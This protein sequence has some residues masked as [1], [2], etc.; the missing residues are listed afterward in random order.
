MPDVPE[1]PVAGILVPA[2]L[3]VA[4]FGGIWLLFAV[5][6]LRGLVAGLRTRDWWT[7]FTRRADGRYGVL[8]RSR[9]FASFRAPERRTPGGLAVRWG[10]WTLVVVGLAAYPVQIVVDAVRLLRR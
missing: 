3:G 8:A 2:A 6:Y 7:P 4:L 5:P 10:A 1:Q 9:F